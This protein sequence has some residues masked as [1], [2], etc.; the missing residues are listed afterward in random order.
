MLV[1]DLD[2][3]WFP[4]AAAFLLIGAIGFALMS[5][6]DVSVIGISRPPWRVFCII[7]SVVFALGL[8]KAWDASRRR[9]SFEL[10]QKGLYISR[11]GP[12]H[13]STQ[14]WARSTLEDIRV[15]ERRTSEHLDETST[16]PE[17]WNSCIQIKSTY[18]KRKYHHEFLSGRE[19]EVLREIVNALRVELG[20]LPQDPKT[21][22]EK[23]QSEKIKEKLEKRAA[24]GD[25]R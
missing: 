25:R 13:R 12:F 9:M 11:F 21:E 3:T 7:C 6:P 2:S 10:R 15:N 16:A 20:W 1:V 4:A 18:K 19:V 24:V 8:L 14:F 23:D 22:R 17:T 5:A